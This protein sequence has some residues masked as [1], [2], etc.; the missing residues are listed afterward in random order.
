[1]LFCSAFTIFFLERF[2][3]VA[4]TFCGFGDYSKSIWTDG[5]NALCDREVFGGYFPSRGKRFFD[6]EDF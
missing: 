2:E 5:Q 1:M 6:F 3:L 4:I